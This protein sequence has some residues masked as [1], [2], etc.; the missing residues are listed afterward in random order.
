MEIGFSME[1]AVRALLDGWHDVRVT[2]DLQG[3]PRVV[4]ARFTMSS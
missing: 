3:I 2:H 1:E 4:A